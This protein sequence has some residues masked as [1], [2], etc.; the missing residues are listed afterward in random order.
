MEK[1]GD[2]KKIPVAEIQMTTLSNSVYSHWTR[3]GHKLDDMPVVGD[4]C[5]ITL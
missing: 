1:V 3:M 4:F 2:R 5:A